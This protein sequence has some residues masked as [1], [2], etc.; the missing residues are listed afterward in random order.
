MTTGEYL[1]SSNQ[2]I[3][4]ALAAEGH[5]NNFTLALIKSNYAS[6]GIVESEFLTDLK[7]AKDMF[8]SID[9][10][11]AVKEFNK[12]FADSM[13]NLDNLSIRKNEF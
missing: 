9:V 13:G 11:G 7:K 3:L 2:G 1:L 10:N 5:I 6:R 12:M 4:I 8:D